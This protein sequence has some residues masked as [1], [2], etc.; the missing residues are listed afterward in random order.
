MLAERH[1]I[2]RRFQG[3][4]P[5]GMERDAFCYDSDAYELGSSSQPPLRRKD[6]RATATFDWFHRHHIF[7]LS[8]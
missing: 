1:T 6:S 3:A 8:G 4:G 7:V 2:D 5:R